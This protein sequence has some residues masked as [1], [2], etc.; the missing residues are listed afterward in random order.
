MAM[1]K[2]KSKKHKKKSKQLRPRTIPQT[3]V[4]APAIELKPKSIA[5]F[6]RPFFWLCLFMIGINILVLSSI[7]YLYHRTI[8]SF[9][10]TPI[11]TTENHLRTGLPTQIVIDKAHINLPIALGSIEHGIWQTAKDKP[12]FLSTS[13]RPGEGNNIVIYGHNTKPIFASLKQVKVGDRIDIQNSEGKLYEYSVQQIQVV[14]PSEIDV[15]LPKD[16]EVLTVY[17]CT[18]LFDSKRLVITASPSRV[19]SGI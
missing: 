13:S 4:S 9:Q 17:T 15:V 12:T 19:S 1:S 7:Y 3:V 18:G 5:W 10:V 11:I 2:H 14:D 6:K 16:H 8:L